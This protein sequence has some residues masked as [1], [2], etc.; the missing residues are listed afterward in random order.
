MK[1]SLAKANLERADQMPAVRSDWK[2][3][4]ALN[5][6]LEHVEIVDPEGQPIDRDLLE[7][8][9]AEKAT[10]ESAEESSEIHP[11]AGPEGDTDGPDQDATEVEETAG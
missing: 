7:T 6:L 1:A 3:N 8:A 10:T 11:E 4:R 2:K 5:W 9:T